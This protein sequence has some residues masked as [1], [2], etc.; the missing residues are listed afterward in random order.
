LSGSSIRPVVAWLA[1]GVAAAE[2]EGLADGVAEAV[3]VGAGVADGL[4]EA[5][6]PPQPSTNAVVIASSAVLAMVV[7][8]M[9]SLR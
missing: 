4:G 2:A 7:R 3:G 1:A 6:V 8:I 9:R 5:V